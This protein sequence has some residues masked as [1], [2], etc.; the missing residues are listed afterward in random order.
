MNDSNIKCCSQYF[1]KEKDRILFRSY[2]ISIQLE[3]LVNVF[4][5]DWREGDDGNHVFFL[6]NRITNSD[7]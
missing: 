6:W 1:F 4:G 5:D 7:I 2:I 3:V